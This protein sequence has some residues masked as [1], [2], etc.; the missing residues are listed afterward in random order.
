VRAVTLVDGR[1][2]HF[3]HSL[4]QIITVVILKDIIGAHPYQPRDNIYGVFDVIGVVV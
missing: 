4:I 1:P 2:V 3:A